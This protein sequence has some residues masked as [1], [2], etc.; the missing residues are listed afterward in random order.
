MSRNIKTTNNTFFL[1]FSLSF[2]ISLALGSCQ[3]D[4]KKDVSISS[5]M[6]EDTPPDF[7]DF[8]IQFHTDSG[9]QMEHILFPLDGTPARSEEHTS[10][11]QSRG[12]LVCRLLL[13]KTNAKLEVTRRIT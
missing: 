10:E 8:Y 12:H 11:L 4:E 5:E 9:Y 6:V 7:Q 2:L 1:L 13:E 3:S